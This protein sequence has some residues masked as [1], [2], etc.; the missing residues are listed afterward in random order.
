MKI[1]TTMLIT[2]ILLFFG[3]QTAYNFSLKAEYLKGTFRNRFGKHSFTKLENVKRLQLNAANM[4]GVSVEQGERE[5]VWISK[6]VKDQVKVRQKGETVTVDFVNFKPEAH[7]Y[8]N[9]ASV[10]FVVN[11]LSNIAARNFQ[12]KGADS[13]NYAGE[14][15]LKGLVGDSFDLVIPERATV[16]MEGSRF[17]VFKAVIGSMN[18][19]SRFTVTGD[20]KLDTAYFDVRKSSL[21]LQSPT[22]LVPHYKL[23]DSSRIELWGKSASQFAK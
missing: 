19:W 23:G 16:F 13:E 4:I 8:I 5:G 6:V 12:V 18:E 3:V 20:N 14:L 21:E 22:I 2:A 17:K 10:V 7:R 1:S 9:S 11:K 15:Y